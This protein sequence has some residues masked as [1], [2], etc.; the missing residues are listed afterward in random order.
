MQEIVNWIKHDHITDILL[1]WKDDLDAPYSEL[2]VG[3]KGRQW[4]FN[5]A[6]SN[7]LKISR[8]ETKQDATVLDVL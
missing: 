7:A 1:G 3:M 2:T 6:H 5:Y 8:L 4:R